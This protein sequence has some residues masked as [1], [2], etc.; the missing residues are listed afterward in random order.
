MEL[1][2]QLL[3]DGEFAVERLLVSARFIKPY[4]AAR[5]VHKG[6]TFFAAYL[7][8]GGRSKRNRFMPRRW[9]VSTATDLGQRAAAIVVALR[10]I[11]TDNLIV[12]GEA[13]V[14]AGVPDRLHPIWVMTHDVTAPIDQFNQLTL[15]SSI[16]GSSGPRMIASF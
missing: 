15:G 9:D 1:G 4:Q 13:I 2:E 11:E 16:E 3:P 7:N 5:E 12:C 6:E 14:N 10:K 8:C